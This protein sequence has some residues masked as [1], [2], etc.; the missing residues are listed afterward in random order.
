MSEEPKPTTGE[1][2][3]DDETVVTPSNWNFWIGDPIVAK[4]IADAHNAALAA[5]RE[6]LIIVSETIGQLR[7]QLAGAQAEL[8]LLWGKD[9]P[10]SYHNAALYAAIAEAVDKETRRCHANWTKARDQA[11]AAAQTTLF[12]A[13][14]MLHDDIADY[15]RINHLGGFQNHAMKAARAALAKVKEGK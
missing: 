4:R 9:F 5:E 12:D 11:V 3:V 14:K 8:K 2:T 7:E 1:W 10:K 15:A 6:N 13:L